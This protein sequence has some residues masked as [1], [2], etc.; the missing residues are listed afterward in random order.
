[1][2]KKICQDQFD[3]GSIGY[4][5]YKPLGHKG[6]HGSITKGDDGRTLFISWT[7]PR[8]VPNK[9]SEAEK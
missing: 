7:N 8:R 4:F 5:C 3:D 1:M 6:R 9:K 2:N